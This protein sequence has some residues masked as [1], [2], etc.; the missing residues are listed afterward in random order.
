MAAAQ[1]ALLLLKTIFRQSEIVDLNA[2]P[3]MLSQPG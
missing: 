1:H 3:N 2:Q